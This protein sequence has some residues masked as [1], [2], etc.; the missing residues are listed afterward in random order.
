MLSNIKNIST[1]HKGFTIV[2]LLIVIVV[3]A[4]LAAISIVA[5]TNI[6]DRG[7]DSA[8]LET[9]RQVANKARAHHAITGSYPGSES[10]FESEDESSLDGA[11][12]TFAAS[13]P[14]SGTAQ[15]E[16]RN[17][18]RVV[19]NS[20]GPSVIYRDGSGTASISLD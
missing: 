9:A 13:P 20:S 14:S 17:G 16:F 12:V 5:Y 2:E 3:I 15:T 6:Q 7:R 1:A 4:I 19:Y 11:N 10:D 18:T 8:A